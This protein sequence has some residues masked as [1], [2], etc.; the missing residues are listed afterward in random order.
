MPYIPQANR[1]ALD[2]IVDGLVKRL[3]D[4]KAKP[5]D[6]NYVVTRV[7]LESLK[8]DTGWSYHSLSDAVRVLKD[9]AAE[10]ER[11][12]LGPYEDTA[13]LKNGD[14]PCYQ[15]QFTKHPVAH[16]AIMENGKYRTRC[17]PADLERV[18]RQDVIQTLQEGL[19]AQHAKR[20]TE[21]VD[22]DIPPS[23]QDAQIAK[24]REPWSEP[25]Q[26]E[27]GPP[28]AAEA[29]CDECGPECPGCDDPG[30]CEPCDYQVDP[31][32]LGDALDGRR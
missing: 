29:A 5:G 18:G 19:A 3:R 8:P 26:T 32:E 16:E 23:S 1:Y 13:I 2:V 11:R 30:T 7:V 17:L 14:M 25:E 27:F 24:R 21:I 31:D 22:G 9:A 15:E 28:T 4:I 12:L 20:L 6:C 10:I